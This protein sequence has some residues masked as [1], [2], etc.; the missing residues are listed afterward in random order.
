[1][2]EQNLVVSKWCHSGG[3]RLGLSLGGGMGKR[4]CVNQN[5]R[6]ELTN[7]VIRNNTILNYPRDVGI[8]LSGASDAKYTIICR[9]TRVLALMYALIPARQ[10][11]VTISFQALSETVIGVFIR[12]SKI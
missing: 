10:I 2:I 12:A 6:V 3:V 1:M 8:H 9:L 11:S 7:R 4:F 5:C